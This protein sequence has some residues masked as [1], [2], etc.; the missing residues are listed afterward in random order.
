MKTILAMI[1]LSL[2]FS[3][4]SQ[5][6]KIVVKKEMLCYELQNV[7]IGEDVQI[8]I[9]KDDLALFEA[10]RDEVKSALEFYEVQNDKYNEECSKWE[11]TK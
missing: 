10:K 9:Y 8:R 7:T 2:L 4:C 3:G 11:K 5:K 1:L 6:E